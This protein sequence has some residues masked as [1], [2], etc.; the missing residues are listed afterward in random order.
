MRGTVLIM[1]AVRF[2]RR[3]AQC[4]PAGRS[5]TGPYAETDAFP[6]TPQGRVSSPARRRQRSSCRGGP[7][8]PPAGRS[9]TGPYENNTVAPISAVGA[10]PRPARKA[11]PW[12]PTPLVKGR[13]PKA[14]GDRESE[15]ERE[16]LILSSPLG[17]S[18]ASF[19]A[20]RKK[21][22]ARRRRNPP[23]ENHRG[24]ASRR[25]RPTGETKPS[26]AAGASPRPTGE[27]KP[28]GRRNPPRTKTSQRPDEGIVPYKGSKNT[29]ECK[30]PHAFK[31]DPAFPK[32]P[33]PAWT[34]RHS[35]SASP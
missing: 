15:Y 16:A 20:S 34:A 14:R 28:S 18:L 25:P 30:I 4:A 1:R 33:R 5:G 21:L 32:P 7:M 24:G 6:D 3:G 35:C 23:A 27:T 29:K 9:G 8:W 13:W 12:G 17:A 2:N 22:A 10:G 26:G 31:K 11:F 19:W